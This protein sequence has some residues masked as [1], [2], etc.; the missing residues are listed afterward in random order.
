[1]DNPLLKL[2]AAADAG[3]LGGKYV[4]ENYQISSDLISTWQL[5]GL[6]LWSRQQERRDTRNR[7]LV[8]DLFE[9]SAGRNCGKEVQQGGEGLRKGEAVPL[10][11]EN[12]PE[13]VIS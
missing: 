11:M 3:Y 9:V 8:W 10:L 6:N 12:G 7:Y 4:D 13:F 1:M 2:G 5:L